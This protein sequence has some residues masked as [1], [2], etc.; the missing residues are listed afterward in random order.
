MN[1]KFLLFFSLVTT[2]LG[3]TKLNEIQICF[4]ILLLIYLSYKITKKG[5]THY[6]IFILLI[7]V[8]SHLL[9]IL[10]IPLAS[11]ILNFKIA[12][13]FLLPILFFKKKNMK[14]DKIFYQVFYINSIIILLESLLGLFPYPKSILNENATIFFYSRPIGL[15]FNPHTS[16]TFTALFLIYLIS[17]KPKKL[18][19]IIIG[20]ICLFLNASWTSAVAFFLSFQVIMRLL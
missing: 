6:D 17:C 15:F 8:F 14:F 3:Q 9:S 12:L 18:F 13:F 4:E 19:L 5:L 20:L 11:A 10:N 7:V 16:S 1:Y 2:M